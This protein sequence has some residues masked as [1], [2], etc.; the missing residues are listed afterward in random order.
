MVQGVIPLPQATDRD[1]DFDAAFM[2]RLLEYLLERERIGYDMTKSVLIT[3]EADSAGRRP[4]LIL[5]DELGGYWRVRV[6]NNGN[7]VTDEFDP[8]LYRATGAGI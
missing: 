6:T 7:L 3:G 1:S 5:R 8:S 2:R 4:H